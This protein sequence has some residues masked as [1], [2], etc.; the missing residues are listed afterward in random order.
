MTL[1]DVAATVAAAAAIF[2]LLVL[3]IGAALGDRGEK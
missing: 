1:P 3:A 2:L